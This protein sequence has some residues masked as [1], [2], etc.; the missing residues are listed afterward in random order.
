MKKIVRILSDI[1]GVTNDIVKEERI[2]LGHQLRGHSYWYNGGLTVKGSKPDVKALLWIYGEGLIK[3][4]RIPCADE[5][6]RSIFEK[7][8]RYE[9]AIK[10]EDINF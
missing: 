4:N 5:T 2:R 1:F 7:D 10:N 9:K 6:R 8:Y 3:I